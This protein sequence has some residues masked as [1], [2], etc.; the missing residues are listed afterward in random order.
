MCDEAQIKMQTQPLDIQSRLTHPSAPKSDRLSKT[1]FV[2]L[3]VIAD[4][5]S[6]SYN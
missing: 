1:C 4:T 5:D 6:R 2:I 3:S